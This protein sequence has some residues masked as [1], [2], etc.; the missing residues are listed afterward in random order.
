[1]SQPTLHL[2]GLPHTQT[3]EEFLH[4][5]Y[6]QK[7][8]KACRM[9]RREG[10]RV[11]LYAGDEN[12]ADCSELVTCI[13]RAEQERLFAEEGWADGDIRAVNWDPGRPYWRLFN[14]R[15][16]AEI[17]KRKDPHDIICLITGA[18]QQQI[19]DAFPFPR[20]LCVEFGVGYSGIAA[21][22]QIYES[23]AWMHA[24]YGQRMG[25]M[26]ADGRFFDAVIPNYFE[27]DDFPFMWRRPEPY[28]VFMSRMTPRK[29]YEIAIQTTE[30]IGAKLLIAGEGGDR[31]QAPH[32]EYIGHVDTEARG[33][34]LAGARG[35]FMSTLYVEP[36]GG[37]AVESMLC[38][39][40]ETQVR[41]VDVEAVHER[42]YTGALRQ[43][44][45]GDTFVECTPEHP[46]FTDRG[47]VAAK[48]LTL[49]DRLAFNPR[50]EE[51]SVQRSGVGDLVRGL[52]SLGCGEARSRTW[53]N[54]GFD[55][56]QGSQ[57]GLGAFVPR[58]RLVLPGDP[59]LSGA[60]VHGGVDR[61]RRLDH[62]QAVR[63]SGEEGSSSR[64]GRRDLQQQPGH[65]GLVTREG[66]YPELALEVRP[67][68]IGVLGGQRQP[69]MVVSH[70]GYELPAAVS[71]TPAVPDCEAT[72]DGD[73]LGVPRSTPGAA[74]RG[75]PSASTRGAG[76]HA[77]VYE[78]A[79]ITAL[80]YREV[81]DL[82]VFNLGTSSGTYEAG[83]LLV[84]NCG[85]P[86]ISTDW[87]A[88][89]E[90]IEQGVDGFRCRTMAEFEAGAEEAARFSVVERRRIR[91]RARKRFGT[92]PVGAMYRDYFK[93][94][95]LLW[96]DGFYSS[97]PVR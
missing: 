88:F 80:S 62:A 74:E 53:A 40:E 90:L 91:R 64:P 61:R 52:R 82:P 83:G 50:H 25:A 16:I 17:N 54:P 30:R 41:A 15:V 13:T 22:F 57:D 94:L 46:F 81:V 76:A 20:H 78:S 92:D 97:R 24:V 68:R 75:R 60:G 73:H 3:T 72:S 10:F 69:H 84:H 58:P 66:L 77:P 26:Q 63:R 86:V 23:Y 48:D 19:L 27:V 67:Q 11:V 42:V 14:E 12:E 36:F 1:M 96:G 7:V 39:P 32:V 9:W 33:R 95:S 49:D 2:C 70:G 35:T 71:G 43:V 65:D 5:A 4:C 85:T 87:G 93:R 37:V 38:F 31:P 79:P 59:D 55:S 56:S 47:W 45:A 29:G 51:G 18:P 28:Y 21:P 44:H 8:V 6:T 89:P 34:L